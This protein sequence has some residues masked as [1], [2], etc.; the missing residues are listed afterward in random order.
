VSLATAVPTATASRKQVLLSHLMRLYKLTQI[1]PDAATTQTIECGEYKLRINPW[2]WSAL[3]QGFRDG[4]SN[5]NWTQLLAEA[6]ALQVK[7]FEDLNSAQSALAND[8]PALTATPST[9]DAPPALAIDMAIGQALLEDLSEAIDG[10]RKAGGNE[11]A[12]SVMQ[13]AGR[14]R[15]TLEMVR[16]AAGPELA[17][18]SDDLAKSYP[19]EEGSLLSLVTP[20]PSAPVAPP[21]SS[22]SKYSRLSPTAKDRVKLLMIALAVGMIVGGSLFVLP[23]LN[24]PVLPEMK[25]ADFSSFK[26]IESVVSRAP[27]LYVR[28]T[29]EKWQSLDLAGRRALVDKVV[30]QV[31]GAGYAGAHFNTTDGKAV[32]RW[33]KRSGTQLF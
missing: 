5:R 29:P 28:M 17:A 22:T 12:D 7:S 20:R 23:I 32:A 18:I 6:V 8:N 19:R 33:L 14:M 1:H 9:S 2:E 30:Q 21:T 13:F 3:M 25:V 24:R 4:G 15:A 16:E 27:N 26:E 10:L 31:E 11:R